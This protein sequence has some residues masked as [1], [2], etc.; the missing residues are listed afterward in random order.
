MLIMMVQPVSAGQYDAMDY[1]DAVDQ[2]AVERGSMV[3]A[4][5]EFT[6]A[7]D[8]DDTLFRHRES[9]HDVGV[10]NG[11]VSTYSTSYMISVCSDYFWS[12]KDNS[13]YGWK[14]VSDEHSLLLDGYN[15]S[16][17]TASGDLDIY[18]KN[19]AVVRGSS[20]TNYASNGIEV[21]G[22][23]TIYVSDGKFDVYGGDAAKQGG[24]AV[25]ST[26]NL[27]VLTDNNAKATFTGG[28]TTTGT[29]GGYGLVAVSS[30]YLIGSRTSYV[31]VVGGSRPNT[32][33]TAHG[34]IGIFSTNVYVGVDSTIKGGTAYCDAPGIRFIDSCEFSAVNSHIT[35]GT[36]RNSDGGAIQN[37]DDKKFLVSKHT[38]V[39]GTIY[40]I[41]IK[42]K[43]YTLKLNGNGGN[44][45][46]GLTQMSFTNYYPASYALAQYI[47]YKSG[48]TQVGWKS[49]MDG[50]DPILPLNKLY[51]P[52]SPCQL[53]AYWVNTTKGDVLLNSLEGKFSDGTFYKNYGSTSVELPASLRYSDDGLMLLGWSDE[54]DSDPAENDSYIYA[55]KWYTGGTTIDPD[56]SKTTVMYGRA[57]N[58]GVIYHPMEGTVKNG[59]NIIVQ[60][61]KGTLNTDKTVQVIGQEKMNVPAGY[62]FAGWSVSEGSDVVRYEPGDEIVLKAGALYNLYAVWNKTSYTY[63]PENGVTVT[64]RPD[65]KNISIELTSEW[66]IKNSVSNS[67]CALCRNGKQISADAQKY[68]SGSNIELSMNYTGSDDISCSIFTADMKWKPTRQPLTFSAADIK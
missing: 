30:A 35:G 58:N 11:N 62:K 19:N 15:G 22:D 12:D 38:D 13:G 59:G 65:D 43:Q 24:Y 14:Y 53:T 31:T 57:A 18:V 51:V 48:S 68:L 1:S 9:M 46:D 5:D 47:F 64:Y 37:I 17:I 10:D 28:K 7:S 23:L 8:A 16:G 3:A 34:G 45:S 67:V 44:T 41:Y 36:T 26:K 52:T 32:G 21:D 6:T 54:L 4:P 66:C 56:S 60:G 40:D 61:S 33:T 42:V 29:V 55:G 25:Y 39:S 20:G 50:D 2:I 27:L 63:S 49:W